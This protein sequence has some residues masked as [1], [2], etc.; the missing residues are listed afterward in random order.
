LIISKIGNELDLKNENLI[1]SNYYDDQILNSKKRIKGKNIIISNDVGSGS[2]EYT[3]TTTTTSKS[4]ELGSSSLDYTTTKTTFITN[5]TTTIYSTK[6][7]SSS[8]L[9]STTVGVGIYFT[10]IYFYLYLPIFFFI[11][12]QLIFN[13]KSYFLIDL[14]IYQLIL[15]FLKIFTFY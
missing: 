9:V 6:L 10:P 4:E 13:R 12:K 5:T 8:V 7:L 11:I 1:I 3:T 2:P 15:I 14:P